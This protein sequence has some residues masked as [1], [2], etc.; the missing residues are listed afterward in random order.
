AHRLPPHLAQ[1]RPHHRQREPQPH[2]HQRLHHREEHGVASPRCTP[3]RKSSSLSA[4]A[5]SSSRIWRRPFCIAVIVELL[6]VRFF[7]AQHFSQSSVV[8]TVTKFTPER[9]ASSACVTIPHAS[10]N[11]MSSRLS[12]SDAW[13]GCFSFFSSPA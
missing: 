1:Q 7:F 12:S 6:G 11:R 5:L 8:D 2:A 10:A 9:R 3:R 4:F 13:K